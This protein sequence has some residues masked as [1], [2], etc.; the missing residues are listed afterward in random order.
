MYQTQRCF[1]K[2]QKHLRQPTSQ[3]GGVVEHNGGQIYAFNLY[4]GRAYVFAQSA[5]TFLGEIIEKLLAIYHQHD[6]DARARLA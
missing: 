5:K 3:S 1:P 2:K 4:I 6:Y